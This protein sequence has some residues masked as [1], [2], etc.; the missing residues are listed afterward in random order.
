[1]LL[2]QARIFSYLIKEDAEMFP[3]K[4]ACGHGGSMLKLNTGENLISQMS[5]YFEFLSSNA[6]TTKALWTSPYLDA[7]GLGIMVTHA[8]PVISEV[9]KRYVDIWSVST[10]LPQANIYERYVK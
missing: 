9:T 3:G 4:L 2:F 1:M 5:N 10:A 8:I 6:K 7:W